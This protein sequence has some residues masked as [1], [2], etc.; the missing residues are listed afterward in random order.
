MVKVRVHMVMALAM[1]PEDDVQETFTMLREDMPDI[2][3]LDEGLNRVM[4][5]SAS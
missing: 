3:G 5:R 4:W 1:V 2:E